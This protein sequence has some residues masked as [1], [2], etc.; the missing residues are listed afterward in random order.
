MHI[1]SG[2]LAAISRLPYFY[3]I[4]HI[5]T[6]KYY[7]G[8]KSSKPNSTTFMKPGGYRTSSKVVRAILVKE[9]FTAF[10]INRILHFKTSA[11][12][13]DYETRFL[14]KVGVPNN[15]RFLNKHTNGKWSHIGKKHTDECRANISLSKKGKKLG[16]QSADQIAKRRESMKG[17]NLNRVRGPQS[18]EQI[19]KKSII[20]VWE[21]IQY[22]SITVA[23]Q[24][25]GVGTGKMYNWIRKKGYKCIA[26]IEKEKPYK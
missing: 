13:L 8:Y 11:D 10:R 18:S 12:A 9:S 26:D 16:P 19:A 4:E 5:A 15:S 23:A 24:A 21:G 1:Y 14:K 22:P 6:G 20:C 17:K 3:I 2:L 7:A 25:N